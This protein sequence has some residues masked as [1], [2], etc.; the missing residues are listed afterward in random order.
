MAASAVFV[1]ASFKTGTTFASFAV[2]D[3]PVY[4]QLELQSSD[5]T[6]F[7]LGF[8]YPESITAVGDLDGSGRSWVAVGKPEYMK[9]FNYLPSTVFLMPVVGP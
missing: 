7:A 8:G 2:V 1:A 9:F 4:G 5:M 3:G 6:T